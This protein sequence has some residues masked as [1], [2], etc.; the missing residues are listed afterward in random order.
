LQ[1]AEAVHSLT[2]VRRYRYHQRSLQ[3]VQT[4]KYTWLRR[5][6]KNSSLLHG[7]DKVRM[8]FEDTEKLIIMA[9]L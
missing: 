3:F 6:E 9:V 5:W 2:R 1:T 8:S 4:W 7:V